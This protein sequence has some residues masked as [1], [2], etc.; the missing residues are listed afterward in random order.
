MGSI[1]EIISIKTHLK[2]AF[3]LSGILDLAFL[4][5]EEIWYDVQKGYV[6]IISS[7]YSQTLAVF[8]VNNDLV[9]LWPN[10]LC[11]NYIES[12]FQDGNL[13]V[14][15]ISLILPQNACF[16]CALC[17]NVTSSLSFALK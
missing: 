12:F 2:D 9:D 15:G 1:E 6:F 16:L 17:V 14:L 10:L 4:S 8:P 3:G 11:D 5:I 7:V 13:F